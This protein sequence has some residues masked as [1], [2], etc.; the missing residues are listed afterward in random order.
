MLRPANVSSLT[1]PVLFT[2]ESPAFSRTNPSFFNHA[3]GTDGRTDILLVDGVS[4]FL[5]VLQ[6]WLS[7]GK[8]LLTVY[9]SIQQ[10]TFLKGTTPRW[11]L[12]P[13]KPFTPWGWGAKWPRVEVVNAFVTQIVGENHT[14]VEDDSSWELSGRLLQMLPKKN[15]PSRD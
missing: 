10:H 15:E 3:C 5:Q 13:K 11:L 14:W 4:G 2:A 9:A 6:L 7:A 1:F 8:P 12:V